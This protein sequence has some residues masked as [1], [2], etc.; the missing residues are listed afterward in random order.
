ML[1]TR[2]AINECECGAGP[3]LTTV[4]T[5]AGSLAA[6]RSSGAGVE[7]AQSHRPAQSLPNG[8]QLSPRIGGLIV[9]D[10]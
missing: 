9:C 10:L 3:L 4:P 6:P 5:G 7:P 1:R 8:A 2:E